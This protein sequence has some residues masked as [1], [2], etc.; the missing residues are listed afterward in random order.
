M[1]PDA[2]LSRPAVCTWSL[3]PTSDAD[4]VERVKA[5]GLDRVQ[6]ALDG[7]TDAT[8]AVLGDAGIAVVSGMVG[9]VGE[10]YSTIARIEETGGVVPDA[11]WPQTRKNMKKAAALAG[12]HGVGL[13]TLHAG[14]IPED[15]DD[16]VF[17]KVQERLADAAGIFDANGAAIALETGQESADALLAMLAESGDWI[18]VNFDPANMLL[19]GSGDPLEA[20]EKLLPHVRQVHLKDAIAS[21]TPGEWGVEVALGE[22]EV[23]WRRFFA[24]L[25]SGGFAGPF[26]IEREAGERR[27]EDVRQAARLAADSAGARLK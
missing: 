15:H 11:T 21:N 19:Y 24:T 25:A 9:A 2:P 3:Q 8:F 22:G 27:V 26:A 7:A 16:P 14:F 4:L 18:G 17:S 5:T 20:V 1:P 13:V 10:D 12:R 23:D 6:L